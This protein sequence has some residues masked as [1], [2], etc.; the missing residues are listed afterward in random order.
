V[1]LVVVEEV[2]KVF[3]RRRARKGA[4]A[5]TDAAAVVA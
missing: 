2:I 4:P 1:S 5:D 3:I